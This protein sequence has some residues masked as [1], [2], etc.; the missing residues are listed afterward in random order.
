[1]REL[2]CIVCPKGCHLTVDD[3]LHVTGNTCKRGEVYGYN[4]VTNPTRMITSTVIVEGGEIERLPVVTSSPI[5]KGKI[6]EVMAEINKQKVKAPVHIKDIV[7]DNVL[8]LG[9]NIVAARNIEK[10]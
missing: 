8:G 6:F 7:I 2:I 4:E 5:P 9:V 10:R 3:N 1:M